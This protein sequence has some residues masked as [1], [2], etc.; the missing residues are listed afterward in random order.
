MAVARASVTSST[1][2]VRERPLTLS[3]DLLQTLRQP[4]R[5]V[6]ILCRD[7]GE[8]HP[9]TAAERVKERSEA[10]GR[11]H[12]PPGHRFDVLGAAALQGRGTSNPTSTNLYRRRL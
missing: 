11:A 9:L 10:P 12:D 3:G 6:P 8:G 4:P 7:H 5:S 2:S 1:L